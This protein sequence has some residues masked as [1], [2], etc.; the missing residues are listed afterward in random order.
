MPANDP[1]EQ[2]ARPLALVT[3]ASSGIGRA[4]AERLA[5]D[6]YNLVLVARRGERLAELK[7]RLEADHGVAVRPLVA[8]LSSTAGRRAV[9]KAVADPRIRTVIDCAALAHYMAFTDLPVETAEELVELNVLAPVR[10]IHAAL[11]AMIE[12]GEGT[13]VTFASLLAFA[14]AADNPR[15]PRRA[16]YGASKAFL[17]ALIRR[18]SFELADTGVRLQVVCPAVV[19]TEF[20]TRQGMDFSQMPRLEPE[21]IVQA[22]MV[23]LANGELVCLPSLEDP[24]LLTHRDE[25][26][27]A[28]LAAGMRAELAG[29]YLVE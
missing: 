24:D 17:L 26:E 6:G 29:R 23:G 7:S 20:H 16:I 18:L 19:K 1:S 25:A 5:A 15:L 13:I 22:S 10:L 11:P 28:I 21:H 2:A 12:R 27:L 14:A 9:E 3:G 8:D 4:Y